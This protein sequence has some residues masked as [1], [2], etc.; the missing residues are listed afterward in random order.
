MMN[1]SSRLYL[2]NVT[3]LD[4]IFGEV[5]PCLVECGVFPPPDGGADGE[6]SGGLS[7][8]VACQVDAIDQET[9]HPV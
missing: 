5:C 4:V 7:T 6:L 8:A 9:A 1:S 2:K 3:S